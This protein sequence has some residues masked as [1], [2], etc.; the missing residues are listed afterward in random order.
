FHFEFA[1]LLIFIFPLVL[2]AALLP[3]TPTRTALVGVV[4]S[5]PVLVGGHLLVSRS[6]PL[7]SI[8][9]AMMTVGMGL[10]CLAATAATTVVSSVIN[11]LVTE[12]RQAQQLGQYTLRQKIGEGGMGEVYRAE[13]AMLRRPT[14]VKLLLPG[15]V[16]HE[17]LTRFEREVQ[18]TSLLA[19]PNTV[20]IYDYGRTPDGIFYYAMEYLDGVSL[21][22]LVK[23]EGPQAPSH[24]VRVMAQVAGALAEAHGIGL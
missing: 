24:V 11:G 23:A 8:T 17:A 6:P 1:A 12:V 3:S 21:D 5:V 18:L 4:C 10:W 14:A 16:S 2:R 22:A 7:D 13:H 15:R 9:P 19:H 20:V